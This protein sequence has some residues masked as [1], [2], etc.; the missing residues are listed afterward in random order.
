MRSPASPRAR[1]RTTTRARLRTTSWA[2]LLA[3]A[4]TVVVTAAVPGAPAAAAPGSCRNPAQ[5][6]PV[7]PQLSWHQRWLAPERIWPV[8]DGSGVRVAVIDSGVDDDHPQLAG[9]VADGTDLLDVEDSG[10][11]DCASH[12]TAVA[13]LIAATRRDGVGFH[14]LAPGVTI[15]PV[16]VTERV[17]AAE[18]GPG[19]P[20]ARLA[21]AIDVAVAAGADVINMSLTMYRVDEAVRAAVERARRA[22]VVLVAAAGNNHQRGE[23]PDPTPYP[24]GFDG[25][26]G[27]GAIDETGVRLADSQV[28]GYVDLVAPGGAVVAASRVSG[29]EVLSGTSYATPMV[30]AAA[31]LL[32]AAEPQLSAVEVTRRLLATADPAAGG[33]ADGYG[34][35]VVNP[36][37][38]IT[39]QLSA[40]EPVAVPALPAVTEDPAAVA[41]AQRW[42]SLGLVAVAVAAAVAMIAAG[43]VVAVTALPY[44]R[45]RR[46]RPTRWADAPPG[47]APATSGAGGAARAGGDPGA[48]P[49]ETFFVVPGTRIR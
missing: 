43:I 16:R 23:V 26:I 30:S 46:W 24:A 9:R 10:T 44:G 36:Y 48:D 47:G 18:E 22:D 4:V 40:A 5:P 15:V 45:R 12:G 20:G 31:A 35:G 41:R 14:G 38:A 11:V 34:H 33:R 39:E 3:A 32:R 28:G 17:Q 19:S 13:S 49:Q 25:V 27:V 29:H 6:G 37:R 42:R 7:I 8:T 2:G 1:L 21:E